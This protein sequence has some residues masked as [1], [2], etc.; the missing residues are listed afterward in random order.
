[1]AKNNG[2]QNFTKSLG[3]PNPPRLI[4]ELFQKKT[5]FLVLLFAKE[6]FPSLLDAPASLKTMIKIKKSKRFMFARFFQLLSLDCLNRSTKHYH[7][8][9]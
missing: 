4:Q 7:L 2:H 6:S 3:I 1:M 9:M 5:V 8:V